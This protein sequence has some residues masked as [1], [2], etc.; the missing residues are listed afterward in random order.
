VP[1]SQD[2]G[3]A[4]VCPILY[5]P[6][7]VEAMDY[8]RAI[9]KKNELSARALRLTTVVISMNSANYTAWNFRR[10][11][12]FELK[13]D[14]IAELKWMERIA[15]QSPKN[16]QLWNHRRLVLDK[17]NKP[18]DEI[19]HTEEV[20]AKDAKNYHVWSHRQW[21]LLRF[22]LIANELKFVDELLDADIRN[23]SAWNQRHFAVEHLTGFSKDVIAREIEYCT[24]RIK[25]VPNN[26]SAWNYLEGLVKKPQFKHD[27]IVKA[28]CLQ[29]IETVKDCKNA[30]SVL[31]ELYERFYV[32][33]K[34][35][36]AKIIEKLKEID[37]IRGNYW[38][39]RMAQ[40][41]H[42]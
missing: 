14:L 34:Q 16:Y 41:G 37:A 11:C 38:Q 2:D 26:D 31:F 17:L 32:K 8:F 12:L 23:N 10:L 42:R 36:A 3:P 5:R 13:S 30:Y 29:V 4:P 22:N 35:E 24:R 27:S 21:V 25:Q 9:L 40:F 33:E 28:L 1:L 19:K 39:Y 6:E 20:L 7:F 18:V 15:K